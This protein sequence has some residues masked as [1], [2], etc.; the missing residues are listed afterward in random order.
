MAD[1][2]RRASDYARHRAGFPDAFF[3]RLETMG[4]MR[5]GTFALD[6]GTGTGTLARGFAR[7]DLRVTGIDISP[8]LLEQARLLAR[9]ERVD[10][11]FIE[12][13][14]ESTGLPSGAFDLVSAGQCWHWFDGSAAMQECRRLLRP[15]GQIVI[16]HLDWLPFEGN[17]VEATIRAIHDFGARFPVQ[18]DHAREGLYPEWTR[19]LA[20]GGF[21]G[22]ETF[23]FDVELR[24]TQEAW[25]GRVRASAAIGGALPPDEVQ[26]F[27]AMFAER[28]RSFSDPIDVI[29]RVWAATAR[30]DAS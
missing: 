4:V 13:P 15:E 3:D 27:D 21:D 6:L 10:V 12:A 19:D 17:L 29:H 28:I 14:A 30:R 5:R 18:L 8:K 9:E 25:R 11:R 1:F 7:R 24:Y 16:A 22:I 2:G 23:S 20:E 26:R